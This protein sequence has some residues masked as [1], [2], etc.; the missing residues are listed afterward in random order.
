MSRM[1][2][3]LPIMRFA[4]LIEMVLRKAIHDTNGDTWQIH[5]L[6]CLQKR[7]HTLSRAC[8]QIPRQISFEQYYAV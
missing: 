2:L 1:V 3:F 5:H 8:I 6:H 4:V 7:H